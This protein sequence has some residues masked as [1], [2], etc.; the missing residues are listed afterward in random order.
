MDMDTVLFGTYTVGTV[1]KYGGIAVGV[2]A[3]LTVAMKIFGKSEPNEHVQAVECLGCGWRG[4]V[5]RYAGRCP[6]CNTPL[7]DR[8]AGR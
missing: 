7:G 4:H 1:L 6:K 2:I 5:S 3:V 8:K